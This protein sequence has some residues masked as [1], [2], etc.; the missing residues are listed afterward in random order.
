MNGRLR[1][2]A[3]PIALAAL[4][5]TAS[6]CKKKKPAVPPPQAEA[7]T[8]ETPKPATPPAPETTTTTTPPAESTNTAATPAP[9]PKP[10][11]PRPRVAKKPSAGVPAASNTSP[12]TPPPATVASNGST[13]PPPPAIITTPSGKVI[14][15][16]GSVSDP[17]NQIST[18][19][20]SAKD[21][22]KLNTEH[23]LQATEKDL[24]G[25]SWTPSLDQK[26]MMDQIKTYITQ[27]RTANSE[28]DV[29]RASNLAQKARLLCDELLK[30]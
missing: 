26:T 27:S 6:G 24:K 18:T 12:S 9:A 10:R 4:V 25:I 16:E 3:L 29:L 14:V 1:K 22:T 21:E 28:G 23:S 5:F 20:P 30:K 2:I 7:P 15:P 13:P 17:T 11:K 8:L 19:M